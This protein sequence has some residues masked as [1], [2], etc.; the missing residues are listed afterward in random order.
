MSTQ[1]F[2]YTDFQTNNVPFSE[3]N[4]VISIPTVFTKEG[5]HIGGYKD[6]SEIE[7]AA[8]TLEGKPVT[9]LHPPTTRPCD[10]KKDIVVGKAVNIHTRNEDKALIGTV[11]IDAKKTPKWLVEAV[12]SGRL[13]GGSLGYWR[14]YTNQRGTYMGKPY[15]AVESNLKFDHYAI[16]LANGAAKIEDGCGLGFNSQDGGE[17]S[18]VP[19]LG[20]IKQIFTELFN[21]KQ[22]EKQEEGKSE[23]SAEDKTRLDKLE[24][25][26]EKFTVDNE[27]LKKKLGEEKTAR[28]Q[29]EGKLKTYTDREAK[30]EQDK[31]DALV[32][33]LTEGTEDKPEIYKDF[34]VPQLELIKA[35][36]V[37][38]KQGEGTQNPP[39]TA[40]KRAN[41]PPA[42]SQ[43]QNPLNQNNGSIGNSLFGKPMG[44]T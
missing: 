30:A 36:L 19:T 10:P 31:K 15:S 35:K 16:G 12:K 33:E 4:G 42:K 41:A 38:Q 1:E 9:L 7:K 2:A 32:K 21:K 22:P 13:R 39:P 29:A 34:S 40:D 44:Q 43:P 17:D 24:K 11:E 37:S 5:V 23:M 26:I 18:E 14:D 8:S 27:D 6:F 20:K 25:T 28:E 3:H